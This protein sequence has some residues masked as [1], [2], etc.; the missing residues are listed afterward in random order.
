MQTSPDL[1]HLVRL[2]LSAE[3]HR[4]V[5]EIEAGAEFV[6]SW[7][8]FGCSLSHLAQAYAGYQ[9]NPRTSPGRNYG[10]S[11]ARD[12]GNP[13]TTNTLAEGIAVAWNPSLTGAKIEDTFVILKDG[14]LENPDVDPNWPSVR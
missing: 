13:A 14:G 6:P 9:C 5:R 10:I 7:N 8:I 1:S 3:L 4:H 2:G 11:G 12:C